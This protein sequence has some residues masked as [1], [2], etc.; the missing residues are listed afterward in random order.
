MWS[1]LS[2]FL[3]TSY[4]VF[5]N[6]TLCKGSTDKSAGLIQHT[7]TGRILALLACKNEEDSTYLQSQVQC[8]A[9]RLLGVL[10]KRVEWFKTMASRLWTVAQHVARVIGLRRPLPHSLVL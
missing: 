5:Y 1:A 3:G 9:L 4:R 8:L 2:N 10:W 7:S 6:Q